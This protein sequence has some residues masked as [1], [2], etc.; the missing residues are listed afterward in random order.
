MFLFSFEYSTPL[1]YIFRDLQLLK[2][3]RDS[4]LSY[5]L[6]SSNWLEEENVLEIFKAGSV[7]T[8][9]WKVNSEISHGLFPVLK[10]VHFGK[11]NQKT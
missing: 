11:I 9:L 8:A 1:S 5:L 3:S 2:A 10:V 7:E 6:P 4:K